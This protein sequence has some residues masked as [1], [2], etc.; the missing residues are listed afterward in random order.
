MMVLFKF[1]IYCIWVGWAAFRSRPPWDSPR[2]PILIRFSFKNKRFQSNYVASGVPLNPMVFK[3]SNEL[4]LGGLVRPAC[5][6]QF[7]YDSHPKTHVS[8]TLLPLLESPSLRG[9]FQILNK[10]HLGGLAR[11]PESVGLGFAAGSHSHTI[12]IQKQAFSKQ[13]CGFWGSPQSDGFQV[14]E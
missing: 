9:S 7:S 6:V 1:L 11:L 5:E 10:L 14:F 2:G 3:F 8:K 13:L 12:L 4:N